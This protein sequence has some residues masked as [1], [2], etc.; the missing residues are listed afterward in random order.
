M[1]RVVAAFEQGDLRPLFDA[2]D[3]E[4]VIWKSGSIAGGPFGFSGAFISRIGVIEVTSLIAVD[5]KFRR[6][7]PKEI[8]SRGEVVWGLFDVAGDFAPPGNRAADSRPF[9]FEC[10]LRWRVQAGK[11]IEHHAFFDTEA[12]LRQIRSSKD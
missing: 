11:I 5:Y 12:L 7:S 8:I 2:I 3:D 4:G 1:R 6:F 10:A 9:E